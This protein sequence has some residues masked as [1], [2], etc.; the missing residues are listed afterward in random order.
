MSIPQNPVTSPL[1][2]TPVSHAVGRAAV[3]PSI[4]ERISNYVSE[5]KVVVYTVGAV[6]V[7]AGAG[8]VY[9]YS[10]QASS[11][12]AGT[13]SKSG[14]E[15]KRKGDKKKKEKE[16]E[17]EKE[18]EDVKAKPAPK[19]EAAEEEPLPEVTEESVGSLTD[20]Q[21]KDYANRLKL[22]GNKSYGA[23][24]YP[25]A[26]DLYS[27]AI[28]CR[29]DPIFYS[30]RSAC[31]NALLDWEKVIEDTSAAL[32]LD[33]E[34]VK[35]LNRRANAYE[36]IE[37]YSEALLDFTASCIIDSF[38]NEGS[39]QSVERLL[40]KLAET[41]GKAMLDSKLRKLPSATFVTNYLQSFRVKSTPEGLEEH[42]TLNDTQ[43]DYW[44]RVGLDA[45]KLKTAAAYDEAAAA[46]DKAIELGNSHEALALN[47]R[48][49]FR[50]L[51]GESKEA[52]ED[53][54]KSI[55]L[56]PQMAQS[57]IKRAS[58]SLELG[59]RDSAAE[60]FARAV[61]QNVNDPDIYYHRAQLNF[62]CGEFSEA[63][64]DYQRSIDLDPDFI[65]SHI[66][67]GVTHYKMG[68]IASSMATFRRCI[69]NFEKVPDVYNYFGELLLDQ[70]K[71]EEAIEKFDMAIDIEKTEKP[72]CINVLPLINKAL[73]LFQWKQDFSESEELC[74]KA[75][76]IDPDCDIAVATM[77]QLLLQQ[78]RVT[79]ALTYFERAAELSRTAGEIVNALSYAEATRTQLEVQEKYP[80]LANKLQG[81]MGAAL[82]GR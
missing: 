36:Q 44:L 7:V 74:R 22:A 62:I 49:T 37:M 60:D 77:A 27:R 11:K 43:G 72:M 16:A 58:M 70:G 73:A 48:G 50:Y 25:R 31:Y 40:K 65:F 14:K 76:I 28:L 45:V 54:T 18:K 42:A 15:R 79:E 81:G 38:R 67:L 6:V 12:K 1:P 68:S 32:A 61:I 8:S 17:K 53:L 29:P 34:Y 59:D 75:L 55:E 20:D 47:W 82:S 69:K 78:G 26:I 21:R 35:A 9:Y 5:H 30:N 56:E 3:E 33:P 13:E 57:Y 51:K 41:K 4:W 80:Q 46:F 24:D 10:T 66:Q 39:A 64:K 71:F 63:A 19:V 2:S 52:L 23:K